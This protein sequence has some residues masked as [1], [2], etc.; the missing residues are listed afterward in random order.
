MIVF[1]VQLAIILFV[2]STLS[3]VMYEKYLQA[4]DDDI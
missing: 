4:D 3:I 2:V 1:F